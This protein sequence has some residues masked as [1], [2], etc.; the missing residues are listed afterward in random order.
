MRMQLGYLT[1]NLLIEEKAS[2]YSAIVKYFACIH[3]CTLINEAPLSPSLTLPSTHD[4]RNGNQIVAKELDQYNSAMA[5][6]STPGT[7][8]RT[9]PC[10][11]QLYI[12]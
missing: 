2:Y 11:R 6:F 3:A 5:L 4:S 1:M 8:A 9:A 7:G 12:N 10:A